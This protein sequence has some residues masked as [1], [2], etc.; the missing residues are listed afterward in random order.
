MQAILQVKC[1]QC[2]KS[3]GKVRVDTADMP[4]EIRDKVFNVILAHRADCRYYRAE[5]TN[6]HDDC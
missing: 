5:R 2:N 3:I 6:R 1:G 4:E